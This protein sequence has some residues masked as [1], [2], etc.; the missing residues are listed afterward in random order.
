MPRIRKSGDQGLDDAYYLDVE[1]VESLQSEPPIPESDA[2][3]PVE[4]YADLV[5]GWVYWVHSE[6]LIPSVQP[7]E[8]G[9]LD[10]DDEVVHRRRRHDADPLNRDEAGSE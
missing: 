9:L 1:Y 8:R 2:D 4:V 6:E 5:S 7:R 10:S 3:Q